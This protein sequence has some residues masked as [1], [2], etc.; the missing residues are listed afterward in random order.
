MRESS[1]QEKKKRKI[2]EEP[3]CFTIDQIQLV[4]S[5]STRLCMRFNGGD[6]FEVWSRISGN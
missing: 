5:S 1:R 4:W 6:L 2:G 3:R